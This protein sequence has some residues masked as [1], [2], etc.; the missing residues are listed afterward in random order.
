MLLVD[1]KTV[2]NI[3]HEAVSTILKPACNNIQ[4]LEITTKSAQDDFLTETD[5]AMEEFLKSKLTGLLPSETVG[6]EETTK[7]PSILVERFKSDKPVWIIDPIDGTYN[8]VHQSGGFGPMVSLFYKGSIE[9]AWIYNI[10]NPKG[11]SSLVSIN[12]TKKSSSNVKGYIGFKIKPHLKNIAIPRDINF[13][14]KDNGWIMSCEFFEEILAGEVDFGIF[15]YVTP[16]D[17]SGGIAMM[18]KLGMTAID[19][20]GEQA[21]Y[22]DVNWGLI[23]ARDEKLARQLHQDIVVPLLEGNYLPERMYNKSPDLTVLPNEVA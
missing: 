12:P 22:D 10:H 14:D 23:L 2:D 15:H 8:F 4:N 7:D 20:A 11:I 3:L 21:V 18:R 1:H 16:W 13:L 6:E 5:L 19:W 9:G 17:N